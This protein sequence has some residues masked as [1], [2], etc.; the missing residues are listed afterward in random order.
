[1]RNGPIR[2]AIDEKPKSRFRLIKRAYPRL[3]EY[4]LHNPLHPLGLRDSVRRL[5]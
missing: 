2:I 5:S 1:M 4:C 3:K